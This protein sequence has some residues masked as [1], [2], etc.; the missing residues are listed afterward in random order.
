VDGTGTTPRW[1]RVLR[2]V[3][4]LGG[5]MAGIAYQTVT[6]RVDYGLLAV[7]AAMIGL[8]GTLNTL[9]LFRGLGTTSPSSQSASPPSLPD[10]GRQSGE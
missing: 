4:L 8:T 9:S 2:D 1:F 6:G 3:V 5:G 7:F 10:S